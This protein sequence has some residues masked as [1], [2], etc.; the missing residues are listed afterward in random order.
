MSVFFNLWIVSRLSTE[1]HTHIG[2]FLELCSC[3]NLPCLVNLALSLGEVKQT[4]KIFYSTFSVKKK[5]ISPELC[6][7]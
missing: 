5:D 6:E 1:L 3:A 7:V 2:A 4:A